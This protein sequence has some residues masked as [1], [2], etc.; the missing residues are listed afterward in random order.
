MASRTVAS[1][2]VGLLEACE[3][4]R[5]LAVK[6]HR[7]QKE[8][9]GLVERNQTTCALCGRQGGKTFCAACFLTWDLL[10]RP[11]LDEIAGGHTRWAV[12][13]ANSREQA[14][15]LLGYVRTIVERSPLLRSQLQSA[16]DDRLTFRGNRVLVA[17]PCQDR[18]IRGVSASALVLDE[19]SHFV[20][21][22]WGPRTLNRIWQAARPLLTIYGDEGRTFGISTPSD[23]QDFFGRLFT[24]AE[25]GALP[26]S[27]AFRASTQEL[28]PTVADTFLEAEKLLL[29]E[30]AFRRE[31][32]AEFSP[33]G[34]GQF[35]EEEAV[36]AVVGR[37]HELRPE[38]GTSWLIGLD[39]AFSSDPSAACVVGRDRENRKRLLVA[40]AER[41]LPKRTRKERRAAKTEDQRLDI[42]ANVLDAVA[43]LSRRFSSCPVVTDQHARMLV[44]SGLKERGVP[45][46]IHRT[47]SSSSVTEAFRLLRARI[48]ADSISLP[49]M[50]S[51]NVSC[52]GYGS[53]R[54]R[55]APPSSYRARWTV[56]STSRP[57]SR[58]A[59]GSWSAR[60]SRDR[61]DGSAPS[62]AGA[63]FPPQPSPGA[64]SLSPIT[65]VLPTSE[66]GREA[67][68]LCC[69]QG[70]DASCRGA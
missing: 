25:Q 14:G 26:G 6:L 4:K 33:G 7:R 65:Y 39:V 59:S 17:A 53:E 63:Q 41:W 19:A 20:S 28:N 54:R 70:A 68:G 12:A 16:R 3:D 67:L 23:G 61:R 2:P 50:S 42:A 49:P 66:V 9:L 32:L 64:I 57:R 30:N 18:L 29:G 13:I 62:S 34:A 47:W 37:Y 31:Y 46:V 5:L 69:D 11:D 48:Y 10:L 45:R 40:H 58:S 15:L 56:I 52:A 43:S 8:L 44:E 22:S 35:F 38:R 36:A 51:C 1:V 21:E 24:Q 55:G 60:A 27:V